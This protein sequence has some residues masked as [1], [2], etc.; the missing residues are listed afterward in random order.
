MNVK[1]ALCI[2]LM[3]DWTYWTPN[4]VRLEYKAAL[5]SPAEAHL[6]LNRLLFSDST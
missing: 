6:D 2:L 5:I 3:Q 1:H 4:I